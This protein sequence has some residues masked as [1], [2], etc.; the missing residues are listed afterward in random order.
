MHFGVQISAPHGH[1]TLMAGQTYYFAGRV[2]H[3]IRLARF[4]KTKHGWRVVCLLITTVDFEYALTS[5]PPTIQIN[6]IQL[7]LPPWLDDGD[8]VNYDET[9]EQRYS[10]KKRTYREQANSRLVQI[11]CLLDCE[12]LILQDKDPLKEIA[13]IARDNGVDAH[14][15]RLQ[16]W[17]FAYVL[18]G[19]EFWALKQPTKGVGKWKR[20]E[21]KHEDTRFG[22]PHPNGAGVGW[23]SWTMHEKIIKSYEKKRGL[24]VTMQAIYNNSIRHDFGCKFIEKED[25]FFECFHPESKPFPTYGQFRYQ[26]LKKYTLEEVHMARYGSASLRENAK[27]E[28][29]NVTG[30]FADLLESLEVDAYFVKERPRSMFSKEIMPPLVVARGIC[31]TSGEIVGVGF[32]LG[33]EN[34]DAYR[35]MLFCMAVPKNYI[36]KIYGI[37]PE[38]LLNWTAQGVPSSVTS[39]RGPAGGRKLVADEL[40]DRF[41]IKTI[42]ASHHGQGKAVIEASNPRNDDIDGPPTYIISD[43]NTIEMVKKQ[44]ILAAKDNHTRDISPRLNDEAL[45]EFQRNK[46]PATPHNFWKYLSARLRTAARKMDI[47]QAVRSF[48]PRIDIHVDNH[49]IRYGQHYYSSKKFR[50]SGA[51]ASIA[52]ERETVLK[53]YGVPLAMRYIWVEIGGKLFELKAVRRMATDPE[54]EYLSMVE[55]NQSEA[56]L[57]EVKARTRLSIEAAENAAASNFEEITGK[58]WDSGKR[59][60]GTPKRK[61]PKTDQEARIIA[62]KS[63]SRRAA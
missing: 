5:N 52:S 47:D 37:P 57:T 20:G 61:N 48:L 55:I 9:E 21:G 14:P 23:P 56:A 11:N 26:V 33:G 63:N 12:Q 49:G 10:E 2:G 6:P 38:K 53:G 32:S 46:W 13:R 25:G 44:V 35:S 4:L 24:G 40:N 30:R 50:E 18:H 22:L 54:D 3:H 45:F 8:L 43:L 39:D 28:Q 15:H 60:R 58:G 7:A 17:F 59:V 27:V 16:V 29:G 31:V 41:P 34:S 62:G 51:H 19:H 36:A 42:T 1:G